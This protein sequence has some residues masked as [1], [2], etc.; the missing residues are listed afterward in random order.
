[1]ATR[2]HW[3]PVLKSTELRDEPVGIRLCGEELVLF[4]GPG[5]R[6]TAL[7]D[8]CPH[9]GMRLSLGHVED[10]NIVCPYHGWAFDGDGRAVVPPAR[11]RHACAAKWETIE[12]HDLI[13]VKPS[14]VVARF[15]R[16]ELDGYHHIATFRRQ[17]EAPFELVLD[18]FIEVEHTPT[19]HALLGYETVDGVTTQVDAADDVVHV[20]NKGPQKHIPRAL[21]LVADIA[22]GDEFTDEWWTYFSP[23]Y[24]VYDHVWRDASTAEIKEYLRTVVFFV[25]LDDERTNLI[26][27]AHARRPPLGR[28]GFNLI[29]FGALSFL[30]RYEVD[31]DVE[32]VE[33][34]ADKRTTLAGRK[35]SRF[36]T[37]LGR[38]RERID[39]IYRGQ[40]SRPQRRTPEA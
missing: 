22:T 14:H 33:N 13:W 39:R 37:A 19:T 6:V 25:P 9:R 17:V 28:F 2:D 12:R 16:L 29:A 4:R 35:L 31:L 23:I 11:N 36:D 3:H 40:T 18:N 8:V 26:V 27:S 20:V 34:L 38:A 7:E 30:S 10:G 21:T 5:G 32:M 15:P 24:T 1:M